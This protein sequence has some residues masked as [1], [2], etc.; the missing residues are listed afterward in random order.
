MFKCETEPSSNV[1][2]KYLRIFRCTQ[3]V[4][5]FGLFFNL[6]LAFASLLKIHVITP[7]HR[8][9]WTSPR[10]LSITTGVNSAG[11][12]YAPIG[13]FATEV[14]CSKEGKWAKTI[15]TGMERVNK[16]ESKE[17]TLSKELGLGSLTYS[18]R[19][20]LVSAQNSKKEIDQARRDNRL[21]TL[22]IYTSEER[23]Q[24]M[25]DFV[26]DWINHGSYQVYGGGKDTIHGEGAGCADF[27][28]TLFTIATGTLPPKAWL[29]KVKVPHSLMGDGKDKKV[30]FMNLLNRVDWALGNEPALAFSIADT[31]LVYDWINH[32]LGNGHKHLIYSTHIFNGP[33]MYSSQT[34]YLQMVRKNAQALGPGIPSPSFK[35]QYMTNIPASKIWQQIKL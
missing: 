15:L 30:P 7:Q 3:L 24:Q 13:H 1:G 35:F 8:I 11:D 23:C 22:D 19:G 25:L 27:A 17:I 28:M 29:A 26:E 12:D 31:N 14:R 21:L 33:V 32:R 9:N 2:K 18:F 10:S 4:L 20:A 6:P 34:D 5:F 16:A